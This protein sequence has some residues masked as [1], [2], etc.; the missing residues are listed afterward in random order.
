MLIWLLSD[1]DA[2]KHL[3]FSETLSGFCAHF[4]DVKAEFAVKTRHSLWESVF[5]YL[6]DPKRN[7]M[8]DII[9][10]PHNWTALLAKLGLLRDL[11]RV[12]EDFNPLA[13]P[14]FITREF[15]P[16]ESGAVFSAPWWM[17]APALFYSASALKAMGGYPGEHGLSWEEFLAALEKL[18][19]ANSARGNRNAVSPQPLG[20]GSPRQ[21]GV[22]APRRAGSPDF[23]PLCFPASSGSLGLEDVLP[24]VWSR[25]GGLFSQDLSRASFNKDE[26]SEG[27]QDLLNL[28]VN[29]HAR[30]FSPALFEGGGCFQEGAAFAFSPRDLCS[31]RGAGAQKAPLGMLPWPG[32][33]LAHP[34]PKAGS[35]GA[36]DTGGPVNISNLAVFSGTADLKEAASLLKWLLKPERAAKF[37]AAFSVFPCHRAE[38]EERLESSRQGGLYRRIFAGASL[39]PNITVYPT[40]EMLFERVLW[41]VS[42]SVARRNYSNDDLTR[43]LII[44]QGE[45]DY[46]LSLY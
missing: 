32:Y 24:R 31:A 26:T 6:R 44:A 36:N 27:I 2:S 46:L 18:S 38:F 45:A 41:N 17:E 13:C 4:P 16:G 33:N 10:I 34:Q 5:A 43:E 23:Y 39:R 12:F 22:T 37:T 29:G 40:A 19:I 9:E 20:R 3:A 1:S 42:L 14:E 35:S 11:S 7:P 15:G 28:A 25:G 21:A 8:A 30:L